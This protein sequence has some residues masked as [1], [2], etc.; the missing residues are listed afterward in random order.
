MDESPPVITSVPSP[1]W[2][3]GES[4]GWTPPPG[5]AG[6]AGGKLWRC[7]EEERAPYLH[8]NVLGKVQM[9]SGL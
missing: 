3:T 1:A 9:T 2:R 4:H 7:F 6:T 5:L 8:F